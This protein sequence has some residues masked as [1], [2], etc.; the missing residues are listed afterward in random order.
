[1]KKA[2]ISICYFVMVMLLS[3][4]AGIKKDVRGYI[5]L[6]ENK[7]SVITK[8][9]GAFEKQ[10]FS[11]AKKLFAQVIRENPSS[12]KAEEAA[13]YT[14]MIELSSDTRFLKALD[15]PSGYLYFKNF[16][17]ALIKEVAVKRSQN[18]ALKKAIAE[19]SNNFKR[20]KNLII[21]LKKTTSIREKKLV[22]T[23]KKIRFFSAIIKKLRKENLEAIEKN[24]S[25]KTDIEKLE[26]KIKKLNENYKKMQEIELRREKRER[27]LRRLGL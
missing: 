24:T 18:K 3:S 19:N 4:C 21:D 16:I 12:L 15:K 20:N 8:A 14:F 1:M 11:K 9:K 27:E 7:D 17:R 13:F 23:E 5:C 22:I 2:G 10:A 6:P 26:K 25:L